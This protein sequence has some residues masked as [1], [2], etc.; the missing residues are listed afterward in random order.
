L[1]DRSLVT[2]EKKHILHAG[3][4][5]FRESWA[6]D[7]GFA[8][9][10]LLAVQEYRSV[11]ETLEAF[12]EYQRPDGQLPV[13]LGSMSVVSRFIHSLFQREQPIDGQLTPKYVTGHRTASLDGQALLV[14]G[15]CNY[16][17]HTRDLTFAHRYWE[18]LQQAIA[19]LNTY[20]HLESSLLA[21][22]AFAD[23]ADSVARRGVIL[24]TNVVY[25]KALVEMAQL[26]ANLG[27]DPQAKSF[28]RRSEDLKKDIHAL[29]WRPD[30]GHFVTSL[31]LENL[32]SAGNLLAV[33]WG[34]V[35]R[36]Q[37]DQI[38]DAI[39]EAKMADPV[40]TQVAHPPYDPSYIALE[41]RIGGLGNYHTEGAWLWIGAWH[42][43]A[44]FISGRLDEARRILHNI[45]ELLVHNG[46][47][48][49]VFGPNGQPLSSFW[50]TSEAPLTW[51][52][53]LIIYAIQVMN[54][55]SKV[56]QTI[57]GDLYKSQSL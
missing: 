5:N 9:Y 52:A 43:I 27:K 1:K 14:I 54:N 51:N 46:E 29:L 47:V 12:F 13:K 35:N 40:P 3:Y 15:A 28:L 16:I 11:R 26:A 2:Q 45:S 25:W 34:M 50:Y 17:S 39:H 44:L 42:V 57:S 21:Q 18:S 41:N 56:F 32:S 22:E 6:R 4:R 24:Y 19:W 38:L 7:F 20:T 37:A 30:L 8:T 53:A 33:A 10:G 23:W 49:E 36:K 55:G 31:E 48:H